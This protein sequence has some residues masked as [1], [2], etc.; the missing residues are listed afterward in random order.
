MTLMHDRRATLQSAIYA[1]APTVLP[2]GAGR[3]LIPVFGFGVYSEFFPMLDVPFLFGGGWPASD[4]TAGAP[5]IVISD[6]LNQQVFGGD[7]SVGRSIDLD[8]K[9]YR[10]IGVM[11]PWNPQPMFFD[12][13]DTGGFGGNGPD[14]FVPLQRAIASGMENA[15][16]VN[17]PKGVQPGAGYAGLQQSRCVWLAGM[18]ELD[19]AA[20][21]QDYRRYLDNYAREQQKIGRFGWPPN[22][23][24]RD[25]RAFLDHQHVVPDDTR[26]SLLVALGLLL[27]CLVNTVGLMLAK[28]LR[29]SGEIGV[30]RA[31]GASRRAIHAQFLTEAAVIGVGGSVLGLLLTA[32]GVFVVGRV[33]PPRLADL[34]RID[35]A[36]LLLT[37]A[38][39][40]FASVLAGVYPTFRA[41]RVQPAWQLKTN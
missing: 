8:G 10:V 39:A 30:R 40:I 17:C 12:V 26:V 14:V 22:N 16:A 32:A 11:K 35:P 9:D 18:V 41:A 24:L 1:V 2:A 25:M 33:L 13:V 6:G 29:R 27:V 19:D 38:V 34:A 23:R 31:L 4:D 37:V 28:F 20:A 15:G 7:N 36:L 3:S 21:V 5:V